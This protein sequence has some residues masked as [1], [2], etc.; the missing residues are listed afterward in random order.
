MIQLENV[1]MKLNH[2]LNSFMK[3]E[4]TLSAVGE[5]D[6]PERKRFIARLQ[7]PSGMAAMMV[8]S[9]KLFMNQM[10]KEFRLDEGLVKKRQE[11]LDHNTSS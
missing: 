6:S 3:N 1:S 4:K 9:A 11:V 2:T 10:E 8:N 7:K 5:Q